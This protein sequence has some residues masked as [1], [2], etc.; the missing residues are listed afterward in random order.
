MFGPQGEECLDLGGAPFGALE[1]YPNMRA[2][3]LLK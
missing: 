1:Y 3:V 2:K